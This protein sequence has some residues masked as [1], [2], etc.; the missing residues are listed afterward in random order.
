VLDESVIEPL[1]KAVDLFEHAPSVL[2]FM[3]MLI[4]SAG[5]FPRK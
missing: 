3:A 2:P 4:P 5:L 1:L